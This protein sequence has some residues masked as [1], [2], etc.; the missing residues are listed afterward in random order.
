MNYPQLFKKYLFQLGALSLGVLLLYVT[1]TFVIPE[2]TNIFQGLLIPYFIIIS[3]IVHY[4]LLKSSEKGNPRKF[5]TRFMGTTTIK[6]MIYLATM[7]VYVL[8]NRESAL[9]FVIAF[10]VF[11]LVYTIF[12]VV[13]FLKQSRKI[14]S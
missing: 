4:Y 10:F 7:L 12:E 3:A 2:H 6:L 11:Y 14:Q 5:V 9:Q 1:A 13:L 8:L